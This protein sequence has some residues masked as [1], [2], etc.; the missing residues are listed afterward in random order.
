M[1]RNPER[2]AF[3]DT[4]PDE[5]ASATKEPLTDKESIKRTAH[6][7]YDQGGH[8]NEYVI[9]FAYLFE[10]DGL[11]D[12]THKL[13]RHLKQ[14]LSDEWTIMGR[15]TRVELKFCKKG[16]RDYSRN[17]EVLLEAFARIEQ[18]EFILPDTIY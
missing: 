5:E 18:D 12:V 4:S 10:R 8:Y 13:Q 1:V 3:E 17:D 2:D 15:G 16:E 9:A 14:E 6:V 7:T 11:V